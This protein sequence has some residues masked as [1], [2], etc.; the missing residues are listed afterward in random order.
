[1]EFSNWINSIGCKFALLKPTRNPVF[2]ILYKTMTFILFV[3]GTMN[4]LFAES[5]LDKFWITFPSQTKYGA[6]H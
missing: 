5:N 2:I 1:M 6:D 3:I 4:H